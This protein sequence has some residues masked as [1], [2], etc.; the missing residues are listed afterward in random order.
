[1]TTTTIR[2]NNCL[3]SLRERS[4]FTQEQLSIKSGVPESTLGRI[5]RDPSA[6]L[7]LNQA[8]LLSEAL[9]CEVIDLLP[10]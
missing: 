8:L 9:D 4:G 3:R 6:R 2:V 7:T 10:R 5:D 1:M